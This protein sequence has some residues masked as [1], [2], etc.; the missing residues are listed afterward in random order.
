MSKIYSLDYVN[1]IKSVS[2]ESSNQTQYSY[3][4]GLS[5]ACFTPSLINNGDFEIIS[6][7]K[8]LESFQYAELLNAD[9][10]IDLIEVID[11]STSIFR[12]TEF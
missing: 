6:Q 12:K 9:S 4:N 7:I 11:E 1:S 3:I 10:L 5:F 2:Y 8:E